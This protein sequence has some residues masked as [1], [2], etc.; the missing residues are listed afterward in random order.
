MFRGLAWGLW[1]AARPQEE[2]LAALLGKIVRR[3]RRA[4]RA[5]GGAATAR[6]SVSTPG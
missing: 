1:E 3:L 6:R 2:I 4:P 5:N